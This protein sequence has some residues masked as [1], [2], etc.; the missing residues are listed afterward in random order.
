MAADGS[1]CFICLSDECEELDHT[2][3]K[4]CVCRYQDP[5]DPKID[6]LKM[7]CNYCQNWL[8]QE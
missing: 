2:N 8:C 3:N 7:C 4:C 6:D 5:D 1:E